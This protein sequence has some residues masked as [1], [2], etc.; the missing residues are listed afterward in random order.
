MYE[1]APEAH[2]QVFDLVADA[3]SQASDPIPEF[4]FEYEPRAASFKRRLFHSITKS[5]PSGCMIQASSPAMEAVAIW[6]PP[7]VTFDEETEDHFTEDEFDSPETMRR[8]SFIDACYEQAIASLGNEPQYYLHMIAT[9]G[10]YIG[11]GYA[12]SLI[13]HTIRRATQEAI[14]CTLLSP[15]H[16]VALYQHLGFDI[17]LK[18]PIQDSDCAF[19]SMRRDP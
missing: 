8:L 6:L 9:R 7:D 14:A 16:N 12:S 2:E 11:Q 17:V 4:I 5:I 10:E 1:V 13:Q 18:A 15:Q 3:F 19:Y